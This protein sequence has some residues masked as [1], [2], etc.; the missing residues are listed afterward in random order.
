MIYQPR[1]WGHWIQQGPL[2]EFI[3]GR[4][5]AILLVAVILRSKRPL[6]RA[7]APNP[8]A[9][10]AKEVRDAH[11]ALDALK[12]K[13]YD[14]TGVEWN[15]VGRIKQIPVNRAPLRRQPAQAGG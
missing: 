5:G 7:E 8:C 4:L 12:V 3:I 1:C 15:L 2:E 14:P 13:K 11:R 9:D 10:L 6:E